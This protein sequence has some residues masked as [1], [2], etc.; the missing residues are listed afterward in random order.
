MRVFGKRKAEQKEFE[1]HIQR[2]WSSGNEFKI[3]EATDE[4]FLWKSSVWNETIST[5]VS[6]YLNDKV[7]DR[8]KAVDKLLKTR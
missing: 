8:T 5:Q 3:F 1:S 4:I 6:S 7:N 2:V